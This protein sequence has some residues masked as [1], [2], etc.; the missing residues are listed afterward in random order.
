LKAEE[1]RDKLKNEYNYSDD[2]L[3]S[4]KGITAL[5][6]ALNLEETD[7]N[8]T[9]EESELYGDTENLSVKQGDFGWHDFVM[10]EF[11]EDELYEGKYPTLKGLRRVCCNLFGVLESQITE[12]KSTL[13]ENTPG[14]AYCVYRILL[15]DGRIFYGAADAHRGNIQGDYNIYPVA[16]AENRA[17]ARAYR[18]ALMLNVVAAEEMSGSEKT[19]FVSV[20]SGEY[21]E[22]SPISNGQLTVINSK[23]SQLGISSAKFLESVGYV[24][25]KS[26]KKDGKAFIGVINGYQQNLDSVPAEIKL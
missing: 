3:E 13:E 18:K 16:I 22:D 21:S 15:G 11:H 1:I 9:K 24:E 19:E 20:L 7:F 25:G 26:T 12:L 14:R 4:I 10:S 8:E 2:Q 6:E 5:R 17:E 23:C